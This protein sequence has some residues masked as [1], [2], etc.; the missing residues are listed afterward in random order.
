[1]IEVAT[2]LPTDGLEKD[3]PCTG[4]MF[5]VYSYRKCNITIEG[6]EDVFK[7]YSSIS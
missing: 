5:D 7:P 2:M 4:R 6:D 1:M 3:R